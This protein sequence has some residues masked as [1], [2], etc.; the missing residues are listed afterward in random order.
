MQNSRLFEKTLEVGW[1]ELKIL[2]GDCMS[3][4]LPDAGGLN[5]KDQ[6]L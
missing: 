3:F 5:S 4:E 2:G 6:G 1:L